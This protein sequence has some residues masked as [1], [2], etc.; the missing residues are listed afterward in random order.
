MRLKRWQW[1]CIGAA[2]LL[3]LGKRL[4]LDTAAAPSEKFVIDPEA[5]HRAAIASGAPLPSRIE[6]EKVADF[7]FP[8]TL[9]VAGDGFRM[10]PMVLLSHRVLWPNRSLMI[11]TAMSVKATQVLPGSKADAA[12]FARVEKALTQAD[13]IL[14]TH[15]H[16]DHV[17]G[18]AAAPNFAAIADKVRITR[19]QLNGPKLERSDFPAGTLETLKP[20]DYSGLHAVAP[21]V[22]LQKAPGHS[23]GTQLIYVELQDGTRFLFVG[24]IAWTNDNITRQVGRPGLATLLMKEDRPAVAAQVQALA[25]LP[26]DI[27]LIVA[28]DPLE[29]AHDVKAGLF[30]QGFSVDP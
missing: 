5:L 15:E 10:Q 26:K 12:A 11:D 22:V 8:R 27:H 21:G 4:L 28:H 18:V 30:K 6:V 13:T 1:I 25:L 20:L 24:D 7:A 3:L 2:G 17:G 14:F 23:V 9:A 16:S 19:E 29:F